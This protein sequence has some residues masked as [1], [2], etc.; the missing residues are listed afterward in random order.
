MGVLL[1]GLGLGGGCQSSGLLEGAALAARACRRSKGGQRGSLPGSSCVHSMSA[2]VKQH[3]SV[4]RIGSWTRAC[5]QTGW[6]PGP[7]Q[8]SMEA[9]W[10]QQAKQAQRAS[11]AHRGAAR[12]V[13]DGQQVVE[14]LSVWTC[15]D[16]ILRVGGHWVGMS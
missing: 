4:V 3:Y 8:A 12:Q 10:A 7:L 1:Q 15:S 16:I 13:L 14:D 9:R 2:M 11:S 5:H 6:P